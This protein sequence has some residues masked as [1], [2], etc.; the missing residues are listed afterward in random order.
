MRPL[1]SRSRLLL[2]LNGLA[3]LAE[4]G[5]LDGFVVTRDPLLPH[6]VVVEDGART[7]DVIRAPLALESVE[8]E[9]TE[10]ELRIDR[11]RLF[12]PSLDARLFVVQGP[13]HGSGFLAK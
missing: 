2:P 7:G 13:D 11:Q 5:R 6:G 8:M 3:A 1:C 12:A 10:G 9:G 4:P